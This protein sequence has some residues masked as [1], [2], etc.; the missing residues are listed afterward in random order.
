MKSSEK[1]GKGRA[2][3]SDRCG[4]KFCFAVQLIELNQSTVKGDPIPTT[5]EDRG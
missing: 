4:F 5:E 3:T 1:P 2:V